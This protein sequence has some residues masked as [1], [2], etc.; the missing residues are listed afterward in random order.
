MS[1]FRIDK[2]TLELIRLA[3]REDLG[4]GDVTSE[5][6]IA[7]S[8]RA[9]ARVV[10]RKAGVVAGLALLKP[11]LREFHCRARVTLKTRDGAPVRR[12]QTLAVIEGPAR[13][14]LAAERTLLNFLQ[15]LSGVATLTRAFV[16]ETRGTKAKIYDTRKT[17][18]GWRRL[19]KAAVR[20]GG[21]TNH[22]IGLYDQALV[23]DNHL[24]AMRARDESLSAGLARLRRMRPG[25]FIMVEAED[26]PGVREA[27]EAG[28]DAVLLDNMTPA[29][30]RRM[31]RLVRSM[32][33]G[34][35]VRLEA[36]GGVTLATVRAV[37]RTGVDRISV[38]ALTHSAPALDIA[39]DFDT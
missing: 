39:L 15:R 7:K 18:P 20:A 13:G 19:E 4:T 11:I 5:G 12:G 26:F 24:A 8:A 31:V 25:L 21:G 28:A 9:R 2:P 17:T 3:A 30:M 35:K 37:A 27:V 32:K 10:A 33:G 1:A 38:G 6:L 16:N 36:S 14:I 22:R 34:R 23:K 29:E